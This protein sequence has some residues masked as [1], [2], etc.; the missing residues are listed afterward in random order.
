MNALDAIHL[1][2]SRCRRNERGQAWAVECADGSWAVYETPP[3]IT[4]KT[5]CR[6][7]SSGM[8]GQINEYWEGRKPS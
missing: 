4:H 8:M 5:C 3:L 7:E 6:F 1:A 2:R